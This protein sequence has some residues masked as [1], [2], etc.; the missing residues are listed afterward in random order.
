M[1]AVS[2]N[3]NQPASIALV[4]A[5]KRSL[6]LKR[7]LKKVTDLLQLQGQRLAILAIDQMSLYFQST[8]TRVWAPVGQ[9]PRVHACPQREMIHI[10]GALEV[11]LGREI[12]VPA[13]EQTS[14]VTSNFIRLLL[15]H[16]PTHHILLLLDRAPWHF[17]P[18]IR[19]LL[20]ENDLLE[21][22]Y[23]PVACSDLNPQ[24]HVGERPRDAISHNHSYRSFEPLLA[25]FG[26]YLNQTLFACDFIE[27]YGPPTHTAIL[28]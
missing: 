14:T 27:Q 3:R 1:N 5:S 24:E 10:Y 12:A 11:Q 8:L 26:T 16:F 13:L 28:N 19:Q 17:G 21:L 18:E 15:L 22:T 20:T 2:A 6:T 23:F 4:P 25:D 7:S 9:T